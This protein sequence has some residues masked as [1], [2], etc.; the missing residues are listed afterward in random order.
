MK[1]DTRHTHLPLTD[2]RLVAVVTAFRDGDREA[3]RTLYDAFHVRVYRFCL[4]MVAD[5]AIA[6]D[7]FQETFIRMFEHRSTLRGDNVRSW[8]F[9]IARRVCLNMIR[10]KRSGHEAFDETFHGMGETDESDVA[11]RQQIERA[12]EQLPVAL[13]EALLLREFEGHSYQEIAD[14]VGIDLSLAKVRVFR[15]RLMMRKILAPI[16]EHER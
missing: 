8:L 10:S 7:A 2:D 12:L 3:F 16:L 14:I 15:A 4:R 1:P 9:S 5:E 6:K 11:L 13:R